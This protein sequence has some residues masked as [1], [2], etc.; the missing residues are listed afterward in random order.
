MNIL[1]EITQGIGEKK[2]PFKST[3]TTPGPG[4]Y[5]L[6]SAFSKKLRVRGGDKR[7][8]IW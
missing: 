1:K 5:D 6:P 2:D 8:F 7:A 3:S 4:K